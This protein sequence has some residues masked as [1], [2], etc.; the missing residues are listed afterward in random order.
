MRAGRFKRRRLWVV[1]ISLLVALVG[2][3]LFLSYHAGRWVDPSGVKGGGLLIVLALF[4]VTRILLSPFL[5]PPEE[6]PGTK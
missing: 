3:S 4:V 1:A 6:Y 2:T 5:V